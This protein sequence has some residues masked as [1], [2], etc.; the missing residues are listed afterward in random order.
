MA[1]ILFIIFRYILFHS[2]CLPPIFSFI[3]ILCSVKIY[4][5]LCV[6]QYA[7]IQIHRKPSVG[8]QLDQFQLARRRWI[9]EQNNFYNQLK[10]RLDESLLLFFLAESI[11]KY[12][13]AV[14]LT[15]AF[16]HMFMLHN[17][18]RKSKAQLVLKVQLEYMYTLIAQN[19]YIWF[20]KK[21]EEEENSDD[22]AYRTL[23]FFAKHC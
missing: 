4:I 22:R 14:N 15:D 13:S 11:S 23:K 6:W 9:Y 20:Q 5:N 10:V 3:V 1:T 2:I 7:A 21:K 16:T 12:M 19:I 8:F 17:G 18:D